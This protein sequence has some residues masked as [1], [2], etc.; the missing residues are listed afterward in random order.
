MTL[1]I[2][3]SLRYRKFFYLWLGL[4]ISVAGTQMQAAALLW[5]VRDLTDQPIALGGIGLARILPLIVF[6]LIGGAIADAVDRKKL[7]YL[8]QTSMAVFALLLAIL[9]FTGKITLWSIYFLTAMNAVAVSFDS[10]ARQSLVP[11]LVPAK[12]LPGAFS[13]SSIAF[14]VGAI[15]GPALGGLVIAYMGIG[16]TYLFNALSYGAVIIALILM[17]R[18]PQQVKKR[19]GAMVSIGSIK[20]GVNLFSAGQSYYQR[21]CWTFS[22]PSSRL[23]TRCCQVSRAISSTLGQSNTAGYLPR[24]RSVQRPQQ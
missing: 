6:S 17:G 22:P 10:P 5:N 16:F 9:A 21:C 14:Q 24:S 4:M 2:P 3:P 8:T 1:G 23:Q 18:V 11:N 15:V 20:E 13:M 7:L 12:D 19:E